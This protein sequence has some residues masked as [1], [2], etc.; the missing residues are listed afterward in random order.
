MFIEHKEKWKAR[1]TQGTQQ[2]HQSQPHQ[3]LQQQKLQED[4]KI[5][6]INNTHSIN[7]TKGLVKNTKIFY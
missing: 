2:S 7:K 5:I 6:L 4:E 3:Q 1:R